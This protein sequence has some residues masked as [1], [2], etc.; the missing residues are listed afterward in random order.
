MLLETEQ[1]VVTKCTWDYE[2]T[3]ELTAS[4]QSSLVPVGVSFVELTCKACR[5]SWV[6]RSGSGAGKFLPTIGS[7][8]VVCPNGETEGEIALTKLQ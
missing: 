2:S 7:I 5:A 6:A 4:R 1:F 8:R 3:G